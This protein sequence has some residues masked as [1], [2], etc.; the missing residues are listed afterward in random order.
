M[1]GTKTNLTENLK[2]CEIKEIFQTFDKDNDGLI[3]IKELGT[4]MR[5]LGQNPTEQDIQDINKTYDRDETGKIEFND[6]FHLV[7]QR[8]K[9]PPFEEEL[10]EAFK[11]SDKENYGIITADEI[12]HV[13][14][15]SG[16][17]LNKEEIDELLR[18]LDPKSEGQVNYEEFVRMMMSK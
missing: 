1:Y 2:Y 16:E 4:I 8:M 11:L 7:Q 15:N 18:V 5:A 12:I 10:I 9:D 6:F 13:M 3:L 17:K 14:S